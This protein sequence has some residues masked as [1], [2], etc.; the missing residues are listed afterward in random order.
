ME[1]S[2]LGKRFQGP[3]KKFSGL[4]VLGSSEELLQVRGGRAPEEV[5][6]ARGARAHRKN[7]S[8][9]RCQGPLK[10]SSR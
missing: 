4:G 2:L 10:R 3:Q 5:F 7:P 1:K 6:K 8:G 9:K